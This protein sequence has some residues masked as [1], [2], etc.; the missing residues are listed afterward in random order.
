MIRDNAR[1]DGA[2]DDHGAAQNNA[3]E[4]DNKEE[5][6]FE[7]ASWFNQVEQAEKAD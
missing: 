1:N 2:D 5:E 6:D 3:V 7:L 4:C